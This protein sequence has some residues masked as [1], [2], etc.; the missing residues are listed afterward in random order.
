MIDEQ[1]SYPLVPIEDLSRISNLRIFIG[2][3]GDSPEAIFNLLH[4]LPIDIDGDQWYAKGRFGR[5]N[6]EL[7]YKPEWGEDN[8]ALVYTQNSKRR[9]TPNKI[10]EVFESMVAVK[11][12]LTEKLMA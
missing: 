3:N 5:G 12:T 9:I 1:G 2:Y 8:S 4:N 10:Y 6:L 11:G 7:M